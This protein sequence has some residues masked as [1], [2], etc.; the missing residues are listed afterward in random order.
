MDKHLYEIW[1]ELEALNLGLLDTEQSNEALFKF[2][3]DLSNQ[4]KSKLLVHLYKQD[5]NAR[6]HAND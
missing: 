4:T 2:F 1:L 5:C 6:Y 3:Y